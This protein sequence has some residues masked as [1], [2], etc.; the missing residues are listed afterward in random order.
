MVYARDVNVLIAFV[1]KSTRGDSVLYLQLTSTKRREFHSATI[2]IMQR[3]IDRSMLV[4]DYALLSYPRKQ[5]RSRSP[6]FFSTDRT[7]AGHRQ[8]HRQS[9]FHDENHL[10]EF[11]A[12]LGMTPRFARSSKV[13]SLLATNFTPLGP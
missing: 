8:R 3:V 1:Y 13:T 9:S 7:G 4:K 2:C 12:D 6:I 5:A 11:N 10:L